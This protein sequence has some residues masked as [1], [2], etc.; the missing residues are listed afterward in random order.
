MTSS[1]YYI[2]AVLDVEDGVEVVVLHPETSEGC[3][4]ETVGIQN[5]FHFFTLLQAIF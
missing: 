5:C 1:T 2:K 3:V 4:V